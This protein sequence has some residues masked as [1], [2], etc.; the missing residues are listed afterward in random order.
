MA[1]EGFRVSEALTLT[2]DDVD[3]ERRHRAR[4]ENKTDDPRS[5]TLDPG[6]SL[7][8][9]SALHGQSAQDGS[10]GGPLT[11]P[12]PSQS[13]WRGNSGPHLLLPE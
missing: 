13:P 11:R 3:L 7:P 2:W 10:V 6:A 1:R 5:W 9:G 8:S 4:D 12:C